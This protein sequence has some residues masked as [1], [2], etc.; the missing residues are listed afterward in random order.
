M[1]ACGFLDPINKK[2][3]SSSEF[4]PVMASNPPYQQP[5]LMSCTAS[6][7]SYQFKKNSFTKVKNA[8]KLNG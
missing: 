6:E 4:T 1:T 2:S 3:S 8:Q 7:V 5:Q